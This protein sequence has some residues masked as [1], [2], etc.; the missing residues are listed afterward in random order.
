M[1]VRG[2]KLNLK[3]DEPEE[4]YH[5]VQ[6]DTRQKLRNLNICLGLLN[7]SHPRVF[8]TITLSFS[9]AFKARQG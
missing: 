7:E 5:L 3:L 8:Q 4:F 9:I 1:T 2:H 6:V